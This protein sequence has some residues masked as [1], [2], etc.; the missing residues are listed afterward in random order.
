MRK[1]ERE[2]P[3]PIS[4]SQSPLQVVKTTSPIWGHGTIVA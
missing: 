2:A 1:V 4:I 3:Y